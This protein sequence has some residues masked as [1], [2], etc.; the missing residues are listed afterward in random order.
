MY[1]FINKLNLIIMKKLLLIAGLFL[2]VSSTY[3]AAPASTSLDLYKP[4]ANFY[5]NQLK[6]HQFFDSF[7]LIIDNISSLSDGDF[8]I[9]VYDNDNGG[10][11]GFVFYGTLDEYNS[12]MPDLVD[13]H[14]YSIGINWGG[15]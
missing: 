5:A 8:Y 15:S 13:G 9:S 10:S 2:M 11:G 12:S 1:L 14:S 6:A 3:A 7:H 4:C